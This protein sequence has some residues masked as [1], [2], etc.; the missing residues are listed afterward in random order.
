M[1]KSKL[2]DVERAA[3]VERFLSK[4]KA[5]VISSAAQPGG[6]HSHAEHCAKEAQDGQ[7]ADSQSALILQVPANL[8]AEE[9]LC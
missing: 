5:S 8:C 9:E 7:L 2:H 6:R 1:A 4:Q 3:E